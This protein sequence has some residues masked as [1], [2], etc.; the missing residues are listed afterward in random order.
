MQQ[1]KVNPAGNKPAEGGRVEQYWQQKGYKLKAD[2]LRPGFKFP[3]NFDPFDQDPIL[4]AF[5]VKG[6]DYGNWVNMDERFNFLLGGY[7]AMQDVTTVLGCGKNFGMNRRLGI[8]YGARGKGG[9][10]A[11]HFEPWSFMINLTKNMGW[12]SLGHEYGHALDY[13]FGLYVEP[14][15]SGALSGGSSTAR[16]VPL[17][18]LSKTSLRYAVNDLLNSILTTTVARKLIASPLS[19]RLNNT[20]A[21]Y[22]NRRNEIF[23]R[24]FE[25]WLL[26]TLKQKGIKNFFLTKEKYERKVY[27]TESEFLK[28]LPKINRTMKTLGAKLKT[29]KA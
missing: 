1:Q 25:Q 6:F 14:G 26:Y 28:A 11:A 7:M 15:D 27:L 13:Y 23:A 21:E 20:G 19:V 3:A 2:T 17:N 5:R 4:K 9:H 22:Y 24:L 16:I 29:S 12:H 18:N 10:A 8:A